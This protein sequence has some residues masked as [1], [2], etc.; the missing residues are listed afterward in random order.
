[1]YLRNELEFG[2]A[3]YGEN[4]QAS[5]FI[6]DAL[7]T[8][9]QTDFIP[10]ANA[11]YKGGVSLEG[12]QYGAYNYAYGMIP[13]FTANLLGRN[14]YN[15][16]DFFKGS[17]FVVIYSTTLTPT[18]RAGRTGYEFFPFN[19]SDFWRDGASASL[20]SEANNYVD[21]MGG[22]VQYFSANNLGRYAQQW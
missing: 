15:E 21:F 18:T 2:I 10:H 13:F 8:R 9:W 4:S 16:T 14:I 3:T 7:V 17:I 6:Q 1:G 20:P 19:D 5:T 12:D 22:M 11:G